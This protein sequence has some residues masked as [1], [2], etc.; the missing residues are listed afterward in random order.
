MTKISP[1][2][3]AAIYKRFNASVSKFD[4]G[5]KC[6]PLN[7]GS[8]VCCSTQDAVPVVHKA[9]FKLLK[10]RTDLWK[11]FKPYDHPTR[12]IV[13]ELHHGCCAIECKGVAHCER[14]NRTIAC[15]AFPFFPYMTR[16]KKLLG[17]SVYWGFTDR[18]WMISNMQIVEREFVREFVDTFEKIFAKD[19]TEFDTY[20]RFSADMRRQF[21][22]MKKTIPVLSAEDGRL[23]IVT[24]KTGAVRE[25]RKG[26]HPKF[27]PFTSDAAYARAIRAE[28]GTAPAEGL[29]PI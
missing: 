5:K 26:E 6:S 28:G 2:D 27:A 29:R 21:S 7:G 22:R 11:R 18:C 15:R 14:D 17:L 16:E 25:G 9:E 23:L 10:G 24:P 12:K 3:F 13:E 1:D 20:V 4:C 8:P 19:K